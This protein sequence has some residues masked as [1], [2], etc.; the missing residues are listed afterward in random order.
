MEDLEQDP[1]EAEEGMVLYDPYECS[2]GQ[3]PLLW[4]RQWRFALGGRDFVS[5]RRCSASEHFV[6]GGAAC[7]ARGDLVGDVAVDCLHLSVVCLNS[8]P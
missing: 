5:G 6:Q 4:G 3:Y 7:S 8:K 1:A 2:A